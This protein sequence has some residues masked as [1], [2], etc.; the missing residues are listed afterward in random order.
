MLM[1][2]CL[3][4]APFT[5]RFNIGKRDH[6]RFN[7]QAQLGPLPVAQWESGM[8]YNSHNLSQAGDRI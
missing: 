7:L 4:W 3:N 6:A 2:P 5:R 8:G 1:V